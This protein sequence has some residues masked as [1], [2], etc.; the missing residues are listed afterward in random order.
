MGC[1]RRARRSLACDLPQDLHGLHCSVVE[2]R[3]GRVIRGEWRAAVRS[4][5]CENTAYLICQRHAF[6]ALDV[7]AAPC[8]V[9]VSVPHVESS[10]TG[11]DGSE[12]G[13]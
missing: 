9:H 1:H 12:F 7:C 4:L 13:D 11:N 3:S 5:L 2:G 6:E 8:R 10:D